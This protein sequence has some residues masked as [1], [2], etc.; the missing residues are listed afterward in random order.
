MED[1]LVQTVMGTVWPFDSLS[2][3]RLTGLTGDVRW[4]SR[5]R[6]RWSKVYVKNVD[7]AA[8]RVCLTSTYEVLDSSPAV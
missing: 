4:A 8:S 1:I 2:P 7:V 6:C 5:H 3:H